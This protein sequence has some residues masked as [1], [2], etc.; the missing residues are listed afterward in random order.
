MV[1]SSILQCC[2]CCKILNIFSVSSS[3]IVLRGVTCPCVVLCG[4][5]VCVENRVG[6]FMFVFTCV[7]GCVVIRFRFRCRVGVFFTYFM[8]EIM[9]LSVCVCVLVVCVFVVFCSCFVF[10]ILVFVLE[11][12]DATGRGPVAREAVERLHLAVAVL[13]LCESASA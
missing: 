12:A 5:L 8:W 3:R 7:C 10:V 4:V 9:C 2:I 1:S 6:T 13:S 11:C